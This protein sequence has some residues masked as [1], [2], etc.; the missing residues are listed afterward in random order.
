MEK[1]RTSKF[2]IIN[3]IRGVNSVLEEGTEPDPYSRTVG[4]SGRPE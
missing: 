1:F 3:E 2:G 4:L